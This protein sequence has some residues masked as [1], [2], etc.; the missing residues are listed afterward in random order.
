MHRLCAVS[1]PFFVRDLSI[2]RFWYP[3]RVLD[4][5]L[6]D[7]EGQLCLTDNK[8]QVRAS[9]VAQRIKRLPAMQETRVRSLGWED[10]LEKE[11]ATHSSILAW[12]IPWWGF[13]RSLAGY[14]PRDRKELDTTERLHFDFQVSS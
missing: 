7:T 5:I 9:L 13:W 14:S 4:P 11:M 2:L 12:R 10:P 6:M 8:C 1:M 3:W